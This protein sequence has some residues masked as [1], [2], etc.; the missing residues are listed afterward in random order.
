MAADIKYKVLVVVYNRN[1]VKLL[2]KYFTDLAEK[3]DVRFVK[4]ADDAISAMQDSDRDVLLVEESLPDVNGLRFT[5]FIRQE[6]PATQ[7]VLISET[8]QVD[9]VLKAIRGG[10][11]D[12]LSFDLPI[13]ELIDVIKRAGDQ[14][15]QERKKYVQDTVDQ[16]KEITPKGEVQEHVKGMIVSV[17]SPKGGVGVS[18]LTSN[19]ALALRAPEYDVSIVDCNLQ[20]GDIAMLFNEVPRVSIMALASRVD[21][22]DSK[23][24]ED[25]MTLNRQSGVHILAAPTKIDL[26]ET[27]SG[28]QLERVLVYLRDMYRYTIV[29]TDSHLDDITFSALGVADVVV[30]VVTQEITTI[31]AVRSFLDLWE[32]SKLNR[33][34]IMV[35]VNHFDQNNPLTPKKISESLKIPVNLSIPAD[36]ATMLK[37]SNLGTP[38]IMSDSHSQISKSISSIA[39][40]VHL[41]ILEFQEVSHSSVFK[42]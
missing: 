37:A 26:A 11:F 16:R 7:V 31:R 30:L 3:V 17:Y 25:V 9:T 32:R 1:Q 12:F 23:L 22:M 41:K 35:V 4:T 6:Y 24:I 21:Y 42:M 40:A 10:A 29:N 15:I 14:A 27:L 39:D 5:E 20:F 33:D 28:E 8:K 2:K 19:L 36:H 38:I 18:T 13:E 34:R